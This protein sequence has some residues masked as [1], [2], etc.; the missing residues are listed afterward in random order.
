MGE[1]FKKLQRGGASNSKVR[2][3]RQSVLHHDGEDDGELEGTCIEDLG[4]R[5]KS[6]AISY[7]RN[8]S[9]RAR[10]L[11]NMHSAKRKLYRGERRKKKR[12][13]VQSKQREHEQ[14]VA[15]TTRELWEEN[16]QKAAAMLI[17][18]LQE[19]EGATA[20]TYGAVGGKSVEN[21]LKEFS[22]RTPMP[23]RNSRGRYHFAGYENLEI[24]HILA[25]TEQLQR[26]GYI[27]EGKGSIGNDIV[28]K[29]RQAELTTPN[30][31]PVPPVEPGTELLPI[32]STR[33]DKEQCRLTTESLVANLKR[34]GKMKSGE[35]IDYERKHSSFFDY[36]AELHKQGGSPATKSVVLKASMVQLAELPL[37][38]A[39]RD[40]YLKSLEQ[41]EKVAKGVLAFVAARNHSG[42]TE[43]LDIL[44][45]G[46]SRHILSDKVYHGHMSSIVKSRRIMSMAD[47]TESALDFD[48]LI[49]GNEVTTKIG[50]KDSLWSLAALIRKYGNLGWRVVMSTEEILLV[51]FG[52]Q[53][54]ALEHIVLGKYDPGSRLYVS[55]PDTMVQALKRLNGSKND[56]T[57][58]V[59]KVIY[60]IP[61]VERGR[62]VHR[63]LLHSDSILRQAKLGRIHGLEWLTKSPAGHSWCR[64]CLSGKMDRRKP[65]T[66]WM[67]R[68]KRYRRGHLEKYIKREL[69][70]NEKKYDERQKEAEGRLGRRIV[71]DLSAGWKTSFDG[72]RYAFVAVDVATR[73]TWYFTIKRKRDIRWALSQIQTEITAMAAICREEVRPRMVNGVAALDYVMCDGDGTHRSLSS[74]DYSKLNR[75]EREAMDKTS[76]I[77][78]SGFADWCRTDLHSHAVVYSAPHCHETAA[79]AEAAVKMCQQQVA[80]CL[81]DSPLRAK[82]WSSAVRFANGTCN[83]LLHSAIGMS[84]FEKVYG[85]VPDWNELRGKLCPFGSTVAIHIPKEVRGSS[86]PSVH[87]QFGFYVGTAPNHRGS[88]TVLVN[89]REKVVPV[90][91]CAIDRN[92]GGSAILVRRQGLLK[93]LEEEREWNAIRETSEV[94]SRLKRKLASRQFKEDI[95]TRY[96]VEISEQMQ[97]FRDE[98]ALSKE[99][100]QTKNI[101]K[102]QIAE[103]LRSENLSNPL[104]EDQLSRAVKRIETA[105]E[106]EKQGIRRSKR[107]V[108]KFKSQLEKRVQN[109]E[110]LVGKIGIQTFGSE[111]HVFVVEGVDYDLLRTWNRKQLGKAP[112]ILRVIYPPQHR[113]QLWDIGS[114]SVP[115]VKACS[116]RYIQLT[117]KGILPGRLQKQL[118]EI[119]KSVKKR[120]WK[121]EGKR[122][123]NRD[124]AGKRYNL[125]QRKLSVA[126]LT[127]IV[128][129]ALAIKEQQTRERVEKER[130]DVL[131]KD[132][133]KSMIE[134]FAITMKCEET[135]EIAK[136]MMHEAANKREKVNVASDQN[137]PVSTIRDNG[138]NTYTYQ[139]AGRDYGKTVDFNQVSKNAVTD[140]S[141]RK[142]LRQECELTRLKWV[143]GTRREDES[144]N[145]LSKYR[146]VDRFRDVPE[147][148]K[149]IKIF[150][151]ANFKVHEGAR[152]LKAYKIRN[153]ADGSSQE[154]SISEVYSPVA[155]DTSIRCLIALAGWLGCSTGGC[156]VASSDMRSAFLAN[157]LPTK[158]GVQQV[159]YMEPPR[160]FYSNTGRILQ[161][162]TRDVLELRSSVYGLKDASR[163]LS[164][165]VRKRLLEMGYK[166]CE[167]D[168]AVYFKFKS[169]GTWSIVATYVDDFLLIGSDQQ[170]NRDVVKSINEDDS[171]MQVTIHE[172]PDRFCGYNLRYHKSG[173]ISI[174]ANDYTRTILDKFAMG[175]GIKLRDRNLPGDPGITGRMLE[176]EAVETKKNGGLNKAKL[177]ETRQM[178]GSVLYL[179][180]KTCPLIAPVV[181]MLATTGLGRGKLWDKQWV[182]LLGY[183]QQ[184]LRDDP[185]IFY[186]ERRKGD[187]LTPRIDGLSDASFFSTREGRSLGGFIILYGGAAVAWRSSLSKTICLSTTE[188]EAAAA[189]ELAREL[190]W[191]GQWN[192]EMGFDTT[193][194]HVGIDNLAALRSF[195]TGSGGK[196]SRH[197]TYK[198]QH[199]RQCIQDGLMIAQHVGTKFNLADAMS[200]LIRLPSTF[201]WL[202]DRLITKRKGTRDEK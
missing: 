195:V 95:A 156:S 191:L 146:V 134:S 69:N 41:P 116:R 65:R 14:E 75:Q 185:G 59:F 161:P 13:R 17:A 12:Q 106:Q 64:A 83:Y 155:R 74:E 107:I 87:A 123:I 97:G 148:T 58:R 193:P 82:Y 96:A 136:E 105:D 71:F 160:N 197:T 169:S 198:I 111:E 37:T 7:L 178:L 181:N 25:A 4:D 98:E 129:V 3:S 119:S 142:L 172:S 128:E 38:G 176:L 173:G 18:D 158:D 149:L 94:K 5:I 77:R 157:D 187:S 150:R 39:F 91:Y 31:S 100:R 46:A 56:L 152:N 35:Y 61:A 51:R 104:T 86:K 144:Y 154:M 141:W 159:K 117:T 20:E 63:T 76:A 27:D 103:M 67:V 113:T 183:L 53:Y 102:K 118:F 19:G 81:W 200:K 28:R 1:A 49:Q 90:T 140:G 47:R 190:L 62:G 167:H 202:K 145:A 42:A 147:G 115:E 78:A 73:Y 33:N 50:Q 114:E 143:I 165:C 16:E 124:D 186:R 92:P 125:R 164:D 93:H 127:K 194:M 40:L 36:L 43:G 189:S 32:N 120:T 201:L 170:V 133:I 199:L 109:A 45:S 179:C 70:D 122:F 8:R 139:G 48:G 177:S 44:D 89:G 135:R 34:K 132:N 66:N 130:K 108:R 15:K 11:E 153:V 84:S 192:S 80:S 175:K 6:T 196:G 188:A 29:L 166:Q 99:Q 180:G 2:L 151:I 110:Q 22:L 54:K 182:H 138:D 30:V 131:H 21:A 162:G 72:M 88:I 171:R 10:R 57:A 112:S 126:K 9:K 85:K 168:S 79:V 121:K 184:S 24:E 101:A 23:V 26:A 60:D 163:I 174:D 55:T 137:G 52:L 68:P